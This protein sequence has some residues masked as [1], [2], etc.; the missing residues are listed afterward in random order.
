MKHFI[1]EYLTFSK[2]EVDAI[3]LLFLL[4]LTF[5]IVP[6]FFHSKKEKIVI[7]DEMKKQVVALQKDSEETDSN[8]DESA[9]SKQENNSKEKFTLFQFN[10]N[11]IDEN[12]WKKLG[13]RDK[14]IKTIINYRSKGGKF[15]QPEDIRKIWGLS[16]EETDRIIPYAVITNANNN[17]LNNSASNTSAKAIQ[18]I[19]IN[20]ATV[21]QWKTIPGVDYSLPY[22]IVKFKEKLGGF[23]SINQIKETY[24]VTDSS[25]QLMLPYLQLQSTNIQQININQA[26]DFE[27]SMHPYISKDIAKAIVIYRTQHGAYTKIDDVKKIVFI[28]EEIFN[29]IAPY[30]KVD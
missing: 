26:S 30:I 12:G 11:T 4:I 24:G 29:K 19:D 5:V 2:K 9:T 14:T 22:K 23:I 3:I 17:S 16:K 7:T 21:E 28:K 1:K 13:L 18:P 10:P 27:L 15:K 8:N 20:T 25:F 6:Y